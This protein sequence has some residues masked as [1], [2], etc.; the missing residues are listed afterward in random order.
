MKWY[1]E[2]QLRPSPDWPRIVQL[3]EAT[4]KEAAEAAGFSTVSWRCRWASDT[5]LL[6]GD[7][8]PR[9][10]RDSVDYLLGC[11]PNAK[12]EVLRGQGH[13]VQAEAPG[14]LAAVLKLFF[15]VS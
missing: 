4:E 11:L 9:F 8:S 2:N 5:L 15:G 12:M 13:M 10:I 7:E 14:S 1:L 6:V 3:L